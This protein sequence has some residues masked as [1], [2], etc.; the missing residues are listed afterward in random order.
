MISGEVWGPQLLPIVS[1]TLDR[2]DGHQEAVGRVPLCTAVIRFA[3]G[4]CHPTTLNWTKVKW[5]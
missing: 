3:A 1:E 4:L 2:C 5:K